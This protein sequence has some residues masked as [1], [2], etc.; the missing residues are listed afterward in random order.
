MNNVV[1][2]VQL[3]DGSS[4]N[5]LPASD[6]SGSKTFKKTAAYYLN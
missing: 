5:L 1:H 4:A 3:V 2:F 6:Y